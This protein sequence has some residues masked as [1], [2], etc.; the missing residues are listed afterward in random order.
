MK[1]FVL[2]ENKI[3]TGNEKDNVELETA[4]MTEQLEVTGYEKQNNDSIETTEF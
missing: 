2:M 1:T 3:A 4:S